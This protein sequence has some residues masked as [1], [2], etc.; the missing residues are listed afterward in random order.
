MGYI[1]TLRDPRNNAIKY[2]GMTVNRLK[3]RL[4]DHVKK[5]ETAK[6]PTK[7]QVWIRELLSIELKPTI[8]PLF[9]IEASFTLLGQLE[10]AW[11]KFVREAGWDLTNTAIGGYGGNRKYDSEEERKAARKATKERYR[12]TE[13]GKMK[14]LTYRKSDEFKARNLQSVK[15][16]QAKLKL[17]GA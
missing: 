2:V 10:A 8:E 9:E 6:R 4:H 1:Y 13:S 14:E 15:K 7:T 16:Y 17:R 3:G 12:S 11:I 5:S